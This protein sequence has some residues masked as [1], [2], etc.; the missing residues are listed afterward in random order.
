[1]RLAFADPRDDDPVHLLAHLASALPPPGSAGPTTRPGVGP[2][3]DPQVRLS[4]GPVTPPVLLDGLAERAEPLVIVLDD[5]HL[6]RGPSTHAL[7]DQLVAG[8]PPTV[9]LA[10]ATRAGTG[11]PLARRRAE[12]QLLE[13]GTGEL[14]FDI[15]E[16]SGLLLRAGLASA[17]P[18]TVQD[19]V[20]R[21][22]GWPAAL[23]LAARSLRSE[24]DPAAAVERFTGT[25]RDVA[26]WFAEEVLRH[27]PDD[28]RSFLVR[29]SPLGRLCGPLCDAVVGGSGSQAVLEE[30]ERTNLFVVPLD[31]ERRWYRYHRLFGEMLAGE[32]RRRPALAAALHGRASAW[33]DAAGAHGEAAAHAL[34]A[35]RLV[36]PEPPAAPW[37]GADEPAVRPGRP[38]DTPW[39]PPG[40]EPQLDFGQRLTDREMTILRLFPSPLSLREIAGELF[41]SV[42]TVKTHNRA[43]YRKLG[44]CSRRDA[45]ERA[46]ELALLEPT[47]PTPLRG[48][49]G[50]ALAS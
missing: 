34:E 35:L 32:L 48:E 7:V 42:N 17:P 11:L 1:V 43:I 4:S 3:V 36:P 31:V 41:L 39:W 21:T 29:T 18:S 5:G 37:G 25:H 8:L 15:D 13:L 23:G 22:E 12:G 24:P 44:V 6:V 45:T 47:R 14:R 16:A 28:V 27:L 20:E 9:Q 30:L 19:L 40:R 50:D 10:I 2:N 26:D 49:H 33:F 38:G 46:R